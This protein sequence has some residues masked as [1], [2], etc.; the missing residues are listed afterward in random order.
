MTP[1]WT[2]RPAMK[3]RF[4]KRT[5]A[6]RGLELK[7]LQQAWEIL[8]RDQRGDLVSTFEWRDVPLEDGKNGN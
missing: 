4:V 7:I 1:T 8:G 3:L 2:E 6:A 5:D